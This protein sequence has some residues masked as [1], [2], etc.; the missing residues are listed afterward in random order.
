MGLMNKI[1]TALGWATGDRRVE[2]RG[3]LGEL[4]E[5]HM[6]SRDDAPAD[7]E[8]LLDQ[9]ELHVRA[10][11]GDTSPDVLPEDRP[12]QDPPGSA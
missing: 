12:P 2:A 5:A 8:E 10:D 4:N 6:P 7:E 3:R 1:R 11:R 9:A